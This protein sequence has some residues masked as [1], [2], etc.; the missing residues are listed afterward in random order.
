ME[1]RFKEMNNVKFFVV[2]IL[3][4]FL[5]N[6]CSPVNFKNPF[7]KKERE[8]TTGSG[9]RLYFSP[10]APPLD[11]ILVGKGAQFIIVVR[12]DNWGGS[13]INGAEL[14]VWDNIPGHTL[15]DAPSSVEFDGTIEGAQVL[16]ERGGERR[17]PAL[18]QL[19]LS[20]QVAYE[21]NEIADGTQLNVY[22]ELTFDYNSQFQTR[23]CVKREDEFDPSCSNIETITSKSL[24]SS[25]P[26]SPVIIDR[27]EKTATP[28]DE[29]T[30]F[31]DLKILLRN[32]AGGEVLG[33]VGE[34]IKINTLS[35]QSDFLRVQGAEIQCSP[36]V[37]V[38]VNNLAELN[39][40]INGLN[41]GRTSN[42]FPLHITYDFRYRMR[43]KA[44]PIPLEKIR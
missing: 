44:G 3:F 38:F 37:V 21:E 17:V 11:K 31:V 34:G 24:G 18:N 23:L 4:L 29:E 40:V 1:M 14:L 20:K 43:I 41:T 8:S 6:A 27:I 28:L 22:A 30:F 5:V 26:H 36:Q 10:N 25:A 39:C 33:S 12:A 42:E 35:I 15:E 9:L 7:S 13:D 19:L 16:P 32:Q 2:L